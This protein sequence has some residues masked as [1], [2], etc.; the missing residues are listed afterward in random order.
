VNYESTDCFILMNMLENIIFHLTEYVEG[1]GFR[2]YDPYDALN[3]PI[4]SQLAKSSKWLRIGFTQILRRL[5]FNLRSLFGMPKGHNPKGMGLLLSSYINLY[6]FYNE[7]RYLDTINFLT[8]WLINNSCIGYSGYCWGYNFDWQ[9]RAFFA[10][11]GTPTIVNT[12]FIGHAFLDAFEILK[13][14]QYLEIARS[15]C[16]F[17]LKDLNI[18]READAVCFSYTPIDDSKVYN[19]NYLGASLLIRT[20]SYTHEEELLDYSERAYK[21]STRCQRDDGSWFYGE[22]EFQNWIDSYHTG[23]NLEALHWYEKVMGDRKYESLICKGLEFYLGN[24]FLEDGTPSFY[25]NLMYPIDIHCA[26]QALVTLSKLRGYDERAVPTLERVLRWTIENMQDQKGF[27]YFRKG[28]ILKNKIPYI[29]W[30]Q[31][32]MLRGLTTVLSSGV[33]TRD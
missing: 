19:A 16:D 23:F 9:N 17:I 4:L 6:R 3:S 24:F 32:W 8:D 12:S 33:F 7:T 21:Y 28:R 31:A 1:E 22:A 27:F 29:R 5:P 30:G 15:A 11:K 2:G 25:H 20:Y 18:L 13:I 26:A 14:G 10:P